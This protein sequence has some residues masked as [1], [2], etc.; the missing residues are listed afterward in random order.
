MSSCIILLP[1]LR[2]T[3]G[4]QTQTVAKQSPNVYMGYLGFGTCTRQTIIKKCRNKKG[5]HCNFNTF[6]VLRL[7][8]ATS[9]EVLWATFGPLQS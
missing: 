1:D 8:Y 3:G 5:I 9:A 4:P 2:D 6:F 7:I